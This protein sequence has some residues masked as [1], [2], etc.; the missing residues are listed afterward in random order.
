MHRASRVDKHTRRLK[1]NSDQVLKV[2]KTV[3]SC[4]VS[5]LVEATSQTAIRLPV[6]VPLNDGTGDFAETWGAWKPGTVHWSI[7][8]SFL[9]GGLFVIAEHHEV[10]GWTYCTCIECS[11]DHWHRP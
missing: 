2:D 7:E 1:Q 3:N 6:Y 5:N 8:A 4:M 9:R 11:V 10:S